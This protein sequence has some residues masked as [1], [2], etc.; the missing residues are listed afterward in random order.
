MSIVPQRLPVVFPAKERE[1]TGHSRGGESS[2]RA[3]AR[4]SGEV[5]TVG[6]VSDTVGRQEAFVAEVGLLFHSRKV[7]LDVRPRHVVPERLQPS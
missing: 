2:E 7:L 1:R 6:P 4:Y 3:L 5:D